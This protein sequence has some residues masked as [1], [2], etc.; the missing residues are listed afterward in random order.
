MEFEKKLRFILGCLYNVIYVLDKVFDK[1]D[2]F[3]EMNGTSMIWAYLLPNQSNGMGWRYFL[4]QSTGITGSKVQ[5]Y[6]SD[7]ID[8]KMLNIYII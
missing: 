6:S 3:T 2:L 1:P 4:A 7:I 8:V 5:R